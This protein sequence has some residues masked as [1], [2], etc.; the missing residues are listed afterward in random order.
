MSSQKQSVGLIE[1]RS[2]AQGQVVAPGPLSFGLEIRIRLGA[3]WQYWLLE[4]PVQTRSRWNH[5]HSAPEE[6]GVVVVVEQAG[7]ELP[8]PVVVVFVLP[9]FGMT[10]PGPGL[11]LRLRAADG[12]E[13]ENR[14]DVL[15]PGYQP[16]ADL[17]QLVWPLLESGV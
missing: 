7:L 14:R 10:A 16:S 5:P 6:E 1:K 17:P 2:R 13:A 15:S 4:T 12:L 9:A 3:G 11:G 8:V